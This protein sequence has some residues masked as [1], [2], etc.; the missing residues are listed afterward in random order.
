MNVMI[1]FLE[2]FRLLGVMGDFA[3]VLVNSLVFNWTVLFTLFL[4][5]SQVLYDEFPDL[6]PTSSQ[7]DDDDE[8]QAILIQHQ[9]QQVISSST[10]ATFRW[11][12]ALCAFMDWI[13]VDSGD[14]SGMMGMSRA[15]IVL[16]ICFL[17]LTLYVQFKVSYSFGGS[18]RYFFYDLFY[19]FCGD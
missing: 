1:E 6:F 15:D 14:D 18:Y 10:I 16:L 19:V 13:G 4:F 7:R 11:G 8:S 17:A 5:L 2:D 3:R 9:N 12:L